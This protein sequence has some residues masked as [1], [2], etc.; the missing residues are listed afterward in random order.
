MLSRGCVR[1]QPTALSEELSVTLMSELRRDKKM[2]KFGSSD[3]LM[4]LGQVVLLLGLPITTLADPA[5]RSISPTN[6]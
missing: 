2:R 1:F 3:W 6:I 4:R 5:D